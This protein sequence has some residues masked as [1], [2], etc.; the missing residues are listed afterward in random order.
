MRTYAQLTCQAG[1]VMLPIVDLDAPLYTALVRNF[2]IV[3]MLL[4]IIHSTGRD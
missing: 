2:T 4:V 1:E 3:L